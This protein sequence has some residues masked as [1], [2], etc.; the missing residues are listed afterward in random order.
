MASGFT[1]RGLFER[2]KSRRAGISQGQPR[3]KK[4][5]MGPRS[6]LGEKYSEEAYRQVR[7]IYRGSHGADRRLD[8]DMKKTRLGSI[9]Q[10]ANHPKLDKK[11]LPTALA[12]ADATTL[13]T[14]MV[15]LDHPKMR[16]EAVPAAMQI[17]RTTDVITGGD[18]GRRRVFDVLEH[19]KTTQ[20]NARTFLEAANEYGYNRTM[21]FMAMDGTDAGNIKDKLLAHKRKGET[22][23]IKLG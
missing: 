20:E 3:T 7:S 21:R 6:A 15:V 19:P 12:A 9:Y 10:L 11:N 16:P 14:V 22:Q 4:G 8:R 2:F 17:I 1:F 5:L 23:Q 18:S 13:G